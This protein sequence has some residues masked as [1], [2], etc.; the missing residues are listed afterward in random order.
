MGEEHSSEGEACLACW[1]T[2]RRNQGAKKKAGSGIRL[3]AAWGRKGRGW[4]A[5]IPFLLGA[6]GA[7]SWF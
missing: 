5:E 1:Q 7:T 3:W 6:E 2:A 4:V